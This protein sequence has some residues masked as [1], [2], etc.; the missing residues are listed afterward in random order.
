MTRGQR[1]QLT[2]KPG[3]GYEF[4]GVEWSELI[5]SDKPEE[6]NG[7]SADERGGEV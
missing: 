2:S 1:C 7:D 6:R 5:G 4:A 3:V